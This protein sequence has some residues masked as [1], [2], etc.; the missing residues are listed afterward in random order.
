VGLLLYRNI[1]VMGESLS[2]FATGRGDPASTRAWIPRMTR[3]QPAC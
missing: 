1:A 3:R 2:G